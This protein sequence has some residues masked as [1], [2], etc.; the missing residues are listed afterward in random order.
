MTRDYASELTKKFNQ[1]NTKAIIEKA[2]WFLVNSGKIKDSNLDFLKYL[3]VLP[4]NIKKESAPSQ[5]SLADKMQTA[6]YWKK[7]FYSDKNLV[8]QALSKL[9]INTPEGLQK[10]GDS[11][12]KWKS[13]LPS[14]FG[15]AGTGSSF[16]PTTQK[17]IPNAPAPNPTG[18]SSSNPGA[19]PK[20]FGIENI[21]STLTSGSSSTQV[22][23]LQKYLA[24]NGYIGTDGKPL[25]EDGIYGPQTKAAVMQFQSKN[26]LVADG[27]FGPKS[28]AKVQNIASTNT[29]MN[30]PYGNTNVNSSSN[31]NDNAQ[32]NTND[33]TSFNTGD[34]TQDALLGEL[35]DY[36]QKQEEAGLKLNSKL[37]FDQ[38]TL[39]KFLETAKKQVHPYYKQQ[40][41]NIKADVLRTAPQILANYDA[42]IAGKQSNFKSTLDISRENDAEAGLAFSG[43]RA[44]GEL[45]LQDAQN[46]DLASLSSSYGD[47]LYNL[48]RGAEEKIG[49]SNVN[50]DLGA[51]RNYSANLSGNGQFS[52][53]G[54][55]TPYSS[56]SVG[57][58]S[59]QY[60][61]AAAQEAR[62]QALLT[63]ASN[64]V[65]AGRDYSDLFA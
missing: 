45:N 16:D 36:I 47:K 51:L 55:T 49:S 35:R 14:D 63:S 56:G 65:V 34:P 32:D 20:P 12:T 24:A 22:K 52:S 25:K 53:T 64:S 48:G 27:I 8:N 4:S 30:G 40:I 26:G 50:Y 18:T 19:A 13:G 10:F 57:T 6:A 7:T 3:G 58:G 5:A 43:Q 23:E 37:N 41:D 62:R 28:L 31:A 42:D 2:K 61:E 1:G 46:R 39:D 9:G 21:T 11:M 59:I 17:M 60:D 33:N 15:R 54:T 29:Q 44:K 38:K